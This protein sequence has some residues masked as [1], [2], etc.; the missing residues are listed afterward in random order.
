L[1]GA[2]S[3]FGTKTSHSIFSFAAYIAADADVFPVEAQMILFM[4]IILA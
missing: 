1:P 2:I 3:P 4:F